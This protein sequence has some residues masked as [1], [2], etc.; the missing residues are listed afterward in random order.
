[1]EAR[2]THPLRIEG[3]L[4]ARVSRWLWLVKWF[5][6]IPHYVVLVFLW[7]AFLVTTIVAGF[8]ILFTGRTAPVP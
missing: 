7:V 3:E 6:A 1:M 4:D 5:L 2:Q 8:V